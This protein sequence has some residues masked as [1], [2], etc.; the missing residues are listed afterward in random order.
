MSIERDES[1]YK[2]NRGASPNK[3]A[4]CS[5]KNGLLR[6]CGTTNPNA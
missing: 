6:L 2:Y 3:R 5:L 1:L 4:K